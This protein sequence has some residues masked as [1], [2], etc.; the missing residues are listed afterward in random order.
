MRL[1]LEMKTFPSLFGR[2]CLWATST[3]V[4]WESQMAIQLSVEDA[5]QYQSQST[6]LLMDLFLAKA[7]E[8]CFPPFL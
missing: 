1:R 8:P 2:V 3:N 6:R 7:S 4:R 5:I